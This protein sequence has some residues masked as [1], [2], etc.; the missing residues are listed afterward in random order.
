MGLTVL[1]FRASSNASFRFLSCFESSMSRVVRRIA[2]AGDGTNLM[3]VMTNDGW[4]AT[5]DRGRR[6]HLMLARWRC[7]ELGLPL[8]RSANTGISASIDHRGRVLASLEPREAGVLVVPVEAGRARTLYGVIGN[9]VAWVSL[10][11]LG[12]LILVGVK[13]RLGER[14]TRKMGSDS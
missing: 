14:R 5:S 3:V 2:N 11:G 1:F 13:A 9:A 4:F 6:V 8:A 10:A 7:L 12:A